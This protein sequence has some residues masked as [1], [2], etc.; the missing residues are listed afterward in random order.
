MTD[1]LENTGK[2]MAV[3][4]EIYYPGGTEANCKK[5]YSG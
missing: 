3:S 5:C 2:E 1:K 4:Y